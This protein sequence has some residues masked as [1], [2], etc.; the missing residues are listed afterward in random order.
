MHLI[1]NHKN[2]KICSAQA[3]YYFFKNSRK[4]YLYTLAEPNNRNFSYVSYPNSRKSARWT[5]KCYI[6]LF[7]RFFMYLCI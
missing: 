1:T 4:H 2:E 5:K 3:A 6:F 7:V